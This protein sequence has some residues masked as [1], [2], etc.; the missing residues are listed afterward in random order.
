[1][2]N[3][4]VKKLKDFTGGWVMGDFYPSLRKTR[5]FEVGIKH[6]SAGDSERE[7]CHYHAIEHTV[8]VEGQAKFNDRLVSAGDIVSVPKGEYVAFQAVTDVITVVIKYPSVLN[9]KH[10]RQE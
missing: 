3:I 1:M 7:H 5:K 8:I 4:K 10:Y 2:S 9:D 6:Y